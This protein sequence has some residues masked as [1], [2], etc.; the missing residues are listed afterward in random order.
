MVAIE[1]WKNF[2]ANENKY[3]G[4][5][6]TWRFP[7]SYFSNENPLGYLDKAAGDYGMDYTV[8]VEG[9]K[10]FIYQAAAMLGKVPVVKEEDWI[11]VTGKFLYISSDNRVVL[12][13]FRVINEG[14]K[15]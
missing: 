6:T 10:G 9:P 5:I 14:Y 11:V 15:Q 1:E 4:T 3:K 2:R 13:P 8:F 7:V 12:S